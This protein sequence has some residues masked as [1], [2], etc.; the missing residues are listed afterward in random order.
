MLRSQSHVIRLLNFGMEETTEIITK[1]L[2]QIPNS[3]TKEEIEY[4][5]GMMWSRL[6]NNYSFS[7]IKKIF[8]I[9]AL[10]AASSNWS[11]ID[12]RMV[13][14]SCHQFQYGQTTEYNA[15][16]YLGLK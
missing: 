6:S 3:I 4:L 15:E 1:V 13:Q 7:K 9:A 14:E 12:R 16:K 11:K 8:D 5:G 2:K 10:T